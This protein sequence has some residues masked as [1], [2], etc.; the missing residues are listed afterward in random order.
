[1]WRENL[2]KYEPPRWPE[3]TLKALDNVLAKA[4]KEFSVV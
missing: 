4:K 2:R 1:M 3:D